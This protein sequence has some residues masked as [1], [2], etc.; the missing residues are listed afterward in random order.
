VYGVAAE[1]G[2]TGKRAVEQAGLDMILWTCR[3]VLGPKNCFH[4]MIK[5]LL[6]LNPPEIFLELRLLAFNV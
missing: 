4:H 5:L 1:L 2:A 6:S 3:L